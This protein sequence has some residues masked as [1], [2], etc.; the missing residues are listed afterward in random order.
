MTGVITNY[1]P[2]AYFMICFSSLSNKHVSSYIWCIPP[3]QW[4]FQGNQPIDCAQEHLEDRVVLEVLGQKAQNPLQCQ[5][6]DHGLH[7]KNRR[8]YSSWA[9]LCWAE[10]KGKQLL[11]RISTANEQHQET[12][13]ADEILTLNSAVINT[14]ELTNPHI[15]RSQL[16]N[17]IM[18]TITTVREPI[19]STAIS[20]CRIWKGN[21][22]LCMLH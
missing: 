3:H 15:H 1:E 6:A 5:W 21:L 20:L 4:H 14:M 13:T 22:R 10:K 17:I 19:I 11:S 2:C 12:N 9:V 18:T 8:V 7:V 16:S